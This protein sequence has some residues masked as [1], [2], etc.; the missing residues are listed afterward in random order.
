MIAASTMPIRTVQPIRRPWVSIA[1][2]MEGWKKRGKGRRRSFQNDVGSLRPLKGERPFERV[3]MGEVA[4][5]GGVSHLMGGFVTVV[6]VVVVLVGRGEGIERCRDSVPRHVGVGFEKRVSR[7]GCFGDKEDDE[8]Q[9][10]AG[11]N[12]HEVVRPGP[13]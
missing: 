7:V 13:A 9:H 5:A 11:E 2:K 12:C 8:W 1:Q 3:R 10:C 6:V 4:V